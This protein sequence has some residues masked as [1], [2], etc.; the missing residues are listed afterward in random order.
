MLSVNN[1]SETILICMKKDWHPDE[2]ARH[3]SLSPDEHDLIGESGATRLNFAILLKA[4]QLDGRFPEQRSDIAESVIAFLSRQLGVP[5]DRLF[6][7]GLERENAPTPTGAGA[8]ALWIS[9]LPGR[10][11]SRVRRLVDRTRR[12]AKPGDGSLEDRR[13]WT[14]ARAPRG[15]TQTRPAASAAGHGGGPP[16][17]TAGGPDRRAPLVADPRRAGRPGTDG[18][19]RERHRSTAPVSRAL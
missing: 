12:L 11:R 1:R 3:W 15:A 13:L 2:L 14:L 17:A 9:R 19:V 7:G 5:A 6:R 8:R 18:R 4:F 10:G 16:P